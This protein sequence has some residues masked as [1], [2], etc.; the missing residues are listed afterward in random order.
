M[1]TGKTEARREEDQ[2]MMPVEVEHLPWPGVENPTHGQ[3]F[4]CHVQVYECQEVHA[5]GMETTCAFNFYKIFMR[6]GGLYRITIGDSNFHAF[7][8]VSRLTRRRVVRCKGGNEPQI[9]YMAGRS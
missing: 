9:N 7:D 5:V 4:A 6:G 3:N 2:G 1:T 8:D